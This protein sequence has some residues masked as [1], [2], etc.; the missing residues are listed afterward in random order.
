[1]KSVPCLLIQLCKTFLSTGRHS[2]IFFV[3]TYWSSSITPKQQSWRKA[4]RT[5]L[6]DLGTLAYAQVQLLFRQRFLS[7][8]ES[9]CCKNMEVDVR[10]GLPPKRLTTTTTTYKRASAGETE[11]EHL[12]EG[13]RK[14]D[15][16]T[17]VFYSILRWQWSETALTCIVS[18]AYGSYFTN[19]GLVK[20]VKFL[21]RQTF[22]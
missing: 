14:K 22:L 19:S 11:Y 15:Q 1:M 21:N 10:R 9:V 5:L 16:H 12:G 4:E 20:A 17:A 3:Q 2:F 7:F 6:Q 8:P 18:H 13:E